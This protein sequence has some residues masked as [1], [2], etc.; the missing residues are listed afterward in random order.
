MYILKVC[1]VL[2]TEKRYCVVELFIIFC[3]WHTSNSSLLPKSPK[4]NP[5]TYMLKSNGDKLNTERFLIIVARRIL[6]QFRLNYPALLP[7]VCYV[8]EKTNAL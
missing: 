1:F 3:C 6:L 5:L 8:V 2:E 4:T 7:L